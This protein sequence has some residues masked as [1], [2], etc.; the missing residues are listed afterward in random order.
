MTQRR[1]LNAELMQSVNRKCLQP[2]VRWSH[3]CLP[4]WLPFEYFPGHT[5]TSC[6]Q[7]YH[8]HLAL[9]E[10]RR[11]M[12]F[13]NVA[14]ILCSS[15]GRVGNTMPNVLFFPDLHLSEEN[16]LLLVLDGASEDK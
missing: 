1:V 5:T 7:Y 13:K 3:L 8:P 14:E 6:G 15:S 4:L 11:T 16:I 2:A 10:S 12:R 9:G